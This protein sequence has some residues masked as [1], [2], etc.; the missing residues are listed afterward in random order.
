MRL[1]AGDKLGPYE[2]ISLIGKGG[3]GEVYKAHDPRTNRDVAIKISAEQFSERF[4]RE[5]RAVAALNH[6]NICTLFDVGPNYLVMEY[7]EGEAPQ[8]PLP[9]EEALR[10]AEQMSAALEAAHEK[11]IVHRDL[12]PGNIK[13]KPDGM[14][15]VLDFGLAKM[16]GT[17]AAPSEESPTLSM[18]ATQAGVILGTAAY[19]APEQARGKPVDQRAD[20]W[21]FGVVFH[22]L[23]SGRRLFQGEDLTETL[24]SVV[25][26]KPD[27][28]TVP[29][30][31]RRLL[32]ACLQK[33]PKKRLQAIGDMRLL[34]ED[35]PEVA[36]LAAVRARNWLPWA[37]AAALASAVAAL[38]FIAWRHTRE[39]APRLVKL[40]FAPPDKGSINETNGPSAAVSPDGRRVVFRATVEGKNALWVRDLDSL[41]LRM[42]AGT[43]GG[44]GPFWS[45]DSR[46][47]GFFAQGKLLKIDVTGGPAITICN[48]EAGRGG[49]WNE[50]DVIVFAP[51]A[52][53]G[54]LRV[55]AAGGTPVPLTE[56]DTARK[57]E[58]HRYPWFLP[59][60]RHFLYSAR[61]TDTEKT[62]V[63][64]GDLDSKDRK[65]ILKVASNAVYVSP[66]YLLFARDRT[67]MAQPFDA[68]KLQT[69]GD[70]LP[71]AEQVDYRA[72]ANLYGYFA[73][74]QNGVL[75]YA[76]GGYGG[77]LQLTWFDRTGKSAGTIGK[78]VDVQWTSLSPDGKSVVTDRL[79]AASGNRD[80]WLYDLARGTEQRLTFAENNRFPIWSPDSAR[81]AFLGT[82]EGA[83]KVVAKA[84]N[85]T[86][87][88]EIL[89]AAEKGPT[90]WSRDG[91]YLISTTMNSNPKTGNDIWMLPMTGTA[92]ERK[93]VPV[94][95][96][97]FG[98]SYNRIS[99]DGRWL[100]YQSNESKRGEIYVVGFPGLNGKWQVSVDGGRIPVWSRDGRELYFVS[101][102]NKMMA[103]E[104]KPGAQFQA[105]VPKPLFDVQLGANNASFDVSADGRFLI[106]TPVEQGTTVPMTVVLN[107]QAALKK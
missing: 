5:V 33:D 82:R 20:I 89:E 66:G 50:N 63:L 27:L 58:S 52:T 23:L 25:K 60:G 55:A 105:G 48:V 93:P 87:V 4:D 53:G 96:T 79:D 51:K 86:G 22:E 107:W 62:A 36:P 73:A 76:S 90:D 40:L 94:F 3:M 39:E 32:D 72:G 101:A 57:E 100:A 17:P 6:P 70:A 1:T 78:P 37:V 56:L 104:I 34:L 8:G 69:T 12:K 11:G 14:V 29:P 30:R 64:I 24:A 80:I 19:M 10:I 46:W 74:S 31:V 106:A 54:F 49:T 102:N 41:S 99:P 28:S 103:V 65:E 71:I 2:I 16:G 45:P 95:Q 75:A 81:I 77:S 9:L 15:K 92:G 88:E 21:A 83:G 7:V 38:G 59:D 84:A 67:L 85:G 61:S 98:E 47:L 18:A 26:D 43:D 42:L 35:A 44:A 13:V 97:E 91:R 68:A